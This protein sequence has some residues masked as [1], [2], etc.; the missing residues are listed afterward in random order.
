MLTAVELKHF[1]NIGH[2]KVP[3][4]PLNV[5]VGRNGAGKSNFVDALRFLRDCFVLGVDTAVSWRNGMSGMEQWGI[6]P[7]TP[8][9]IGVEGTSEGKRWRY[10]I[11]LMEE[12]GGVSISRE[13]FLAAPAKDG[14]LRSLFEVNNGEFGQ[15]PK[16]LDPDLGENLVL[17]LVGRRETFRGAYRTLAN[18]E[19]HH[20]GEPPH[21]ESRQASNDPWEVARTLDEIKR[22]S[23]ERWDELRSCVSAIA[24]NIDDID[25]TVGEYHWE[26]SF[27]HPAP[28]PHWRSASYESEGT[29]RALGLLAARYQTP[30]PSLIAVEEP[31]LNLHPGAMGLL[32][33]T[34]VEASLS[35]QIILT[36]HSPDLISR[37]PTD[38]LLVVE[39]VDGEAQIGPIDEAQREIVQ[40]GLFTTGDLL[41]IEG[42][43]ERRSVGDGT[44]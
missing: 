32:A 7:E 19:F 4:G 40:E 18:M 35:T 1:K 41:R 5:L 24:E 36:T 43:L 22:D 11:E 21:R 15:R 34:F 14:A 25:V 23:P 27:H 38:S 44:G 37:F 12:V 10:A 26:I 31:E 28:C 8:V 2:Q 13:A 20:T 17:P 30:E 39:S 9:V 6:P 3:L 42:G 16:G 33:D 29:L